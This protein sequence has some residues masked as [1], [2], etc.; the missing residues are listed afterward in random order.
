MDFQYRL[1]EKADSAKIAE[2]ISMA[3]DGVAEYLF[4][5][6]IPEMTPVQIMAYNLEKDNYPH[7]YKSTIVAA[8][9]PNVVGMAISYPSSYHKI[10][11]EMIGFFPN[12]RLERLSDFYSSHVPDSWFLD[13][14]G[15]DE[16]FRRKGIGT[17]LI[18]LTKER[19]KDHGY[20]ILSLIAFADNSPA[21][22]LY[23]VHGFQVVQEINLEG[24]EFIPHHEG[25]LLLKSNIDM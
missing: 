4:H 9:G 19:A 12:E 15:V 24:N 14:L 11:D 25:C 1:A 22:A 23:K 6:L 16:N 8:D 21:L 10:T 17:M 5:D 7:S 13:A 3:S 20:G 2:L 18:E